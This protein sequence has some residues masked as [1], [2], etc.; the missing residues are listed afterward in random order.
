MNKYA[1]ILY[2]AVL[3]I[4]IRYISVHANDTS[5]YWLQHK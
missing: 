2:Y 1:I 5:F 4:L 3:F